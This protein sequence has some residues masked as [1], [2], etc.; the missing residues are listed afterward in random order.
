MAMRGRTILVTSLFL[1]LGFAGCSHATDDPEPVQLFQD[2][3][4]VGER[5]FA[6]I[7]EPF[8]SSEREI[9]ANVTAPEGTARMAVEFSGEV[10]D[11]A[12]ANFSLYDPGGERALF[13]QAAHGLEDDHGTITGFFILHETVEGRTGMWG[14]SAASHGTVPR[15]G[16]EVH[17]IPTEAPEVAESFETDRAGTF[18]LEV[19]LNGWGE[20]PALRLVDD[21]GTTVTRFPFDAAEATTTVESP[22]EPGAYRLVAEVAGWG[23]QVAWRATLR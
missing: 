21:S 15:L 7:W 9:L 18:V 14:L 22:L 3:H 6:N 19:D 4:R 5:L 8:A 2:K 20:A 10:T 23:G 1:A 16:F 11:E 12:A 13:L 17:T